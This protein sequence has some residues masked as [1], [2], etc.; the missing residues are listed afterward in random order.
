MGQFLVSIST[1]D[2]FTGYGVGGGG[3]AG[4]H[5]VQALL[6]D[7]LLGAEI[8]SI[9]Q[10]WNELHAQLLPVGA[11]GL[12]MMALSAVDLALWDLSG[13]CAQLPVARLLNPMVNLN[14][15][16][17]CYQTI[18]GGDLK[19]LEH[20][21]GGIKLHLGHASQGM[22]IESSLVDFVEQ[23]TQ[24][25]RQ[26]G[27]DRLLMVDAW[28]TWDVE[29]TLRFA[30]SVKNLNLAWIEEPLPVA[31]L[32]GY[33]RL[34][35]Q[36]PIPIAGGEHLFSVREFQTHIKQNLH[37]VLQPDVNWIG[38]LTPLLKIIDLAQSAGVP[39]IPHRGAELWSLHAIA[40]VIDNPLAESAR[41]WM[42]WVGGQPEI[43]HGRIRPPDQPGL[44]VTI[45]ESFP[46]VE[47][48]LRL[49]ESLC[50]RVGQ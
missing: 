32:Q 28:M 13:K 26:I 11:N 33:Q 7:A 9:E 24:A 40:A 14:Q 1:E 34:A 47:R 21:Q 29:F 20:T 5:V 10:T 23:T 19:S 8:T 17:P 2:G 27:E 36:S 25:R 37:Q 44:G 16:V 12:A 31:D 42:H 35:E 46:D 48:V 18:W 3:L 6:K 15:S 45:D 50:L 22:R 41:P 49:N 39:I 30:E 4:M 43:K 38:G